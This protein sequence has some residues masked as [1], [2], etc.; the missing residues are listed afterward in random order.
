[1]NSR[2]FSLVMQN[3]EQAFSL[4]KYSDLQLDKHSIIDD[5]PFTPVRKVLSKF[6]A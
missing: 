1:M 5:M 6:N 4:P 3:L 2:I